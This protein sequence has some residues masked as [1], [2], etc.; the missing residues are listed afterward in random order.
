MYKVSKDTIESI[1][2][3]METPGVPL[4]DHTN[5]RNL[6]DV[7]AASGSYLIQCTVALLLWKVK[8]SPHAN[9]FAGNGCKLSHFRRLSTFDIDFCILI[10]DA[11]KARMT[12]ALLLC[13]SSHTVCARET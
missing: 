6:A 8:P 12:L 4:G 7:F 2:C 5:L 1:K 3:V 9:P 10:V 13:R 11:V